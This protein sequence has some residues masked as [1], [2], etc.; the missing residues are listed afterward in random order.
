[1]PNGN[2][3]QCNRDLNSDLFYSTF[4][5]M[6]L[7]GI[8]LETRIRLIRVRSS[9]ICQTTIKS[10]NLSNTMECLESYKQAPY[11]VAW[12]DS[13]AKDKALGRGIVSYVGLCF[14]F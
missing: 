13:L 7:T 5:G 10:N 4:G 1:M 2:I 8:I 6:G 11:V 3:M 12:I 9:K 14:G